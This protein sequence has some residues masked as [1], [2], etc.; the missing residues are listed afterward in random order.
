MTIQDLWYKNI[1][2]NEDSTIVEIGALSG[3]I[4]KWAYDNWRVKN[5]YAIE[6]STN[7]YKIL[8]KNVKDTSIVPV[9]SFIG[10]D[11][12]IVF[13]EYPSKISSNSIFDK[14]YNK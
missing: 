14:N 5:I 7:N 13:H 3:N 6:A 12:N 1:V 2:L 4:S 11:E 10:N 9:N 8:L